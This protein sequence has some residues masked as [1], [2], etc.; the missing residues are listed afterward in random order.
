MKYMGSKRAML[1]NG[2]GKVLSAETAD[3][4]RFADL[5]VGSGAVAWYV[6]QNSA[7]RVL[8]ADLQLFAVSLA[9]AVISRE[10]VID[11]E[12]VWKEWFREAQQ[13]ARQSQLFREA[14]R[15]EQIKW[16]KAR[17][18]YVA[19]AREM[20]ASS[21]RPITQAYGGHYFS[22]KQALI[23]DALRSALPTDRG[24]RCVAL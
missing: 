17:R 1:A 5:F 12:W 2:L 22:P 10:K 19:H 15:F 21:R 16:G 14:E 3:A 4:S 18:R 11:A 24:K 6:A 13:R 7:C 23:L 9:E 20:C 8:A